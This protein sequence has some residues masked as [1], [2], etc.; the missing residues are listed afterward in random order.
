MTKKSV[1]VP[2]FLTAFAGVLF[3]CSCGEKPKTSKV[4]PGV[5]EYCGK[6][7]ASLVIEEAAVPPQLRGLIPLCK[8]WGAIDMACLR[9]FYGKMT[10]ADK[11]EITAK[12]GPYAAAISAWVV[13][14]D[15][16]LDTTGAA[17]SFNG[18]LML[19]NTVRNSR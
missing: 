2:L 6:I 17:A 8:K 18:L 12:V 5:E 9:H 3:F 14:A 1:F 7:M 16:N 11:R 10:A 19:Y 4:N 15:A 13:D